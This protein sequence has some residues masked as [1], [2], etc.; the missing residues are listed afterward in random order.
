MGGRRKPKSQRTHE[1][2]TKREFPRTR[3]SIARMLSAS[4]Q[5]T[6]CGCRGIQGDYAASV[7][8]CPKGFPWLCAGV[9]AAELDSPPPCNTGVSP[10]ENE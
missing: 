9:P 7:T 4:E 1:S 10:E 8:A 2:S 5:R 6:F 3:R